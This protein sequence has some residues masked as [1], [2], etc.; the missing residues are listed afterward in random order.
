M[1]TIS[2]REARDLKRGQ[3]TKKYAAEVSQVQLTWASILE[4]AKAVDQKQREAKQSK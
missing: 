2:K 1:D 4:A 3:Q